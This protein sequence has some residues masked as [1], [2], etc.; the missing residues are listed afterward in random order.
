MK[1]VYIG[2]GHGGKDPGAVGYLVEKEIN[3]KMAKACKAYLE[4]ANVDVMISRENDSDSELIDRIN[5]CNEYQ[6]DLA[7]DIHNNSGRGD[8]FEVFHSIV[9]GTGKILAQN[10]EEEI[11]GIEQN[12]RGL[13][14][15]TNSRGTDYF[16]FIRETDC[17]A[18]ICE[19]VFVDNAKDAKQADT[20]AECKA[21]GVAY[22]KGI[23]KTLD[24]KE[25]T[26]EKPKN[27]TLYCVQVGAFENRKN[28][29]NYSA[30]LKL[31]GYKA[32]V[33]EKK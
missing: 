24:V 18:I 25:P 8:G 3:L 16:G 12:S 11:K 1:K 15:K 7:I 33:V 14:T 26:E 29:E 22:A 13:K 20:D 4:K 21:F 5:E 23:L 19:G 30:K 27:K 10:I 9:N 17:P 28:A 6:P 2:V 32:Y 31:Q